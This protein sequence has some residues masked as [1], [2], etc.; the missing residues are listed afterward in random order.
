MPRSLARS[1]S[2]VVELTSL[3]LRGLTWLPSSAPAKETEN[4]RLTRNAI[5]GAA[6]RLQSVYVSASGRL[7][8]GSWGNHIDYVLDNMGNRVSESHY[9][10]N[11][12]L[13]K[14]KTRI[15]D[16][17]NRL[18]QDIGGTTYLALSPR[19]TEILH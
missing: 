6:G 16:S 10:A 13:K 8:N 19:L 12:A 9:D 3:C 7:G 18:Q 15:I 1:P 2:D 14:K 11:G 4:A 17:L 5:G